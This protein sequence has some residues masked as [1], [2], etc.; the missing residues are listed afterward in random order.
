MITAGADV[1]AIDEAGRSVSGVAIHSGLQTLW[2]EALKY[3]GID[4]KDVLARTDIDP[5]HSTALSS[6]YS[7]PPR[8]VTSKI[9]LEEYLERRKPFLI[10]EEK[11]ELSIRDLLDSSEDDNSSE[12]E[13]LS[14]PPSASE[15]DESENEDLGPRFCS[16]ED[17]ESED[18]DWAE[19]PIDISEVD[20]KE[21]I[22]KNRE[23]HANHK[24][25][26]AKGKAKL[27]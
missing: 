26:I 23:H 7:Q 13:A 12:D 8:S 4:I 5:A 22:G 25:C 14:S 27:D 1:C 15:D 24:D 16:S 10:P 20:M 19:G 18:L 17:D 9:S 11:A 21:A 3:C 6:E 2:T